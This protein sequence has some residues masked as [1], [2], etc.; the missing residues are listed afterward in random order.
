MD[1]IERMISF[2]IVL[3]MSKVDMLKKVK[4]W[5]LQQHVKSRKKLESMLNHLD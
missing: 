5:E 2:A 3:S 1:F 4:T